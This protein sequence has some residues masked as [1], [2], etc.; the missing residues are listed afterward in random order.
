MTE[1]RSGLVRCDQVGWWG[2]ID[3]VIVSLLIYELLK[4]VRRTHAVQI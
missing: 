1:T 4:L 3:I 2:V